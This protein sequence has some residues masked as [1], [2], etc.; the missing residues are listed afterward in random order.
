M[1]DRVGIKAKSVYCQ[2]CGSQSF[3]FAHRNLP[4]GTRAFI[5]RTDAVALEGDVAIGGVS[6]A[7]QPLFTVT[8]YTKL[9]CARSLRGV[10]FE[11]VGVVSD[12]D[13]EDP[14]AGTPWAEDV[15]S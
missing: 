8:G 13:V 10:R 2:K 12:A 1:N 6:G 15:T 7:P 4:K 9:L 11:P 3:V 5:R 14:I